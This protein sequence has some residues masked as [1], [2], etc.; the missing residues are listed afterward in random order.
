MVDEKTALTKDMVSKI[1]SSLDERKS[2]KE[3]RKDCHE[4]PKVLE[5]RSGAERRKAV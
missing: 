3:R 4:L 1:E 2:K 5:R